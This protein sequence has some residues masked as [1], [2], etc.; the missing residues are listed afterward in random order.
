M[1]DNPHYFSS[2]EGFFVSEATLLDFS[3]AELPKENKNGVCVFGFEI[4]PADDPKPPTCD[5]PPN[6]LENMGCGS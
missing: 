3:V 5:G 4:M 1:V 2:V 6:G